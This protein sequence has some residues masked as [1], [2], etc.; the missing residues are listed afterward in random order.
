MTIDDGLLESAKHL[1]IQ[2]GR[3][4]GSVLEDALRMLLARR[5]EPRAGGVRLTVFNGQLG[6]QPG[7]DLD[8]REA[9]YDLLD[10]PDDE[11]EDV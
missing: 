5:E 10:E 8:D 6:L 4:V 2:E 11:E 7:V 9:L 1:A 3:T